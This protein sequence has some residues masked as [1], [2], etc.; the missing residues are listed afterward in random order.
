[1]AD[2]D[3]KQVIKS[4]AP[5]LGTALGGPLAGTAIKVLGDAIIGGDTSSHF[6]PSSSV[7]FLIARVVLRSRHADGF[8]GQFHPQICRYAVRCH[9]AGR[10]SQDGVLHGAQTHCA[11]LP[12]DHAVTV[13]RHPQRRS[14]GAR[15]SQSP[16][17]GVIQGR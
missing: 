11:G 8:A 3:W 16:C 7:L 14:F 9:L 2:F 13:S 12:G 15:Q 17:G 4:I 5:V 10:H 1:M 6:S